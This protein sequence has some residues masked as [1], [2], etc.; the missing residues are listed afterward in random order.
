MLASG[1][2]AVDVEDL[3][4]AGWPA[5][6]SRTAGE[7]P[8]GRPGTAPRSPCSPRRR[9]GRRRSR[10]APEQSAST[11]RR[12]MP[13]GARAEPRPRSPLRATTIAG[14]PYRSTRR[15]ATMPI[16]PAC[17]AV[18]ADADRVA[19]GGRLLREHP[20]ALRRARRARCPSA[21][22]FCVSSRFARRPASAG[23]FVVSR[24]MTV[25]VR[26]RRPAAL[27]RGPIR[28]AMCSA[29]ILCPSRPAILSSARRPGLRDAASARNPWTQSTR[30]S[31]V[32]DDE[33]GDGR[34]ATR[35]RSRR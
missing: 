2:L 18:A 12:W 4:A 28:N 15:A 21:R 14:T 20:R 32:S 11:S 29:S 17:Q 35:T 19:R 23:S 31:E 6:G 8:P 1:Q 7:R 30:L 13:A 9:R 22:S 10:G 34:D 33:V 16:T 26:P 25:A 24:S 3:A 5:S 27:M